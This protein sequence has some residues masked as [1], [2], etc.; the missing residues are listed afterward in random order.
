MRFPSKEAYL[1]DSRFTCSKIENFGTIKLML[2]AVILN[3]LIF[4][5][6]ANIVKEFVILDSNVTDNQSNVLPQYEDPGTC[7]CDLTSRS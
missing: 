2:M 5:I 4:T 1:R 7:E 6:Q 3:C